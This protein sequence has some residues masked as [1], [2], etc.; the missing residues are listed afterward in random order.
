MS[1]IKT[2]QSLHLSHSPLSVKR[3]EHGHSKSAP[4]IKCAH[5]FREHDISICN[6][7]SHV[8]RQ[9]LG[10][11]AVCVCVKRSGTTLTVD[12]VSDELIAEWSTVHQSQEQPALPAPFAIEP[13]VSR[14]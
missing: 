4:V 1:I 11:H 3:V 5:V 7:M 12:C 9:S 10:L 13:G 14:N 8:G 6:Y 2:G